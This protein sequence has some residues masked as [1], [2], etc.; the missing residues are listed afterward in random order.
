MVDVLED[1]CTR[2]VEVVELVVTISDEVVTGPIVTGNF[3]R[4]V[5]GTNVLEKK[6]G[7]RVS[8]LPALSAI[9]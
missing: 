5:V 4:L 6:S 7:G 2:I 3:V 8:R 9:Q 1:V